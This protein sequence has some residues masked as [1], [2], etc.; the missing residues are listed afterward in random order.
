METGAT[1]AAA[2]RRGACRARSQRG[3]SP[4]ST[5]PTARP[6]PPSAHCTPATGGPAPAHGTHT[7]PRLYPRP[8]PPQ[9]RRQRQPQGSKPCSPAEPPTA[10]HAALPLYVLTGIRHCTTDTAIALRGAIILQPINPR[11]FRC[12]TRFLCCPSLKQ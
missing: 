2:P 10:H 9:R 8:R 12:V 1:A 5:T 6:L 4:R 11:F 3:P 7:P